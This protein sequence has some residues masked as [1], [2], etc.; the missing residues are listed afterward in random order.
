MPHG[1]AL[2]AVHGTSHDRWIVVELPQAP[3]QRKQN[4]PTDL[5][6]HVIVI[7][8]QRAVVRNRATNSPNAETALTSSHR[9]QYLNPSGISGRS[10]NLAAALAHAL[11]VARLRTASKTLFA[12]LREPV[13]PALV[14]P[15]LRRGL[16]HSAVRARL[17]RGD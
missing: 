2:Q 11:T 14:A 6:G 4:K 10:T 9:G 8:V 17:C 1:H 12:I 13:G 5:A 15:E 7:D 16:L 3:L